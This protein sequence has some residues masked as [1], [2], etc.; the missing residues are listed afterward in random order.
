MLD[1][2]EMLVRKDPA[3]EG[4]PG[5]RIKGAALLYADRLR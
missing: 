4:A 2:V 3:N 1:R 5:S